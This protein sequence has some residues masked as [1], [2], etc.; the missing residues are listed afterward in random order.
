MKTPSE[1]EQ[2][3]DVF[4]RTPLLP[5]HRGMVRVDAVNLFRRTFDTR[6]ELFKKVSDPLRRRIPATSRTNVLTH[7]LQT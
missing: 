4:E 2:R 7:S 1:I 3:H 5:V 6:N